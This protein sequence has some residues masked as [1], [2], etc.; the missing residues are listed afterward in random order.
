MGLMEASAVVQ[1]KTDA[2][3]ESPE[4]LSHEGVYVNRKW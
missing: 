3:Y 2:S 4:M 1:A